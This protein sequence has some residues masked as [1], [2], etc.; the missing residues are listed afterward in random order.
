M[1]RRSFLQLLS[2]GALGLSASGLNAMAGLTGEYEKLTILH[3]NDWHSRIDPFPMDGSR[4]EGLGGAS[5]RAALI[6]K[7]RREEAHVLLFDS[8]DI[9][10]GT[11]YFNVYGGE[12]EFKLMSAMQYDAATIGNHDFDGGL[13]NLAH[14]MQQHAAFDFVCANYKFDDPILKERVRPYQIYKKGNIKVGVFGLGIELDG[15]VPESLFGNTKYIDPVA[16]ANKMA[17]HLKKEKKCDLV[18]CLS[19]LGYKYNSGY[20]SDVVVAQ[21]T[22]NVDII[23]G[24]HTHTFMKHAVWESNVLG[25]QVLINQVGWA[26]ILLGRIDIYF[27]K[28]SGRT[29]KNSKA[30]EVS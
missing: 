5:K 7:I 28:M 11:P 1:K 27:E 14:Q 20:V 6:Q 12:L 10:Q 13:D 29:Q 24:G 25:K 9:F 30:L 3:T 2:S 18:V 17:D 26:G 16:Q 23:L 21:Q 19:H 15:L 8:G 22:S 4:N